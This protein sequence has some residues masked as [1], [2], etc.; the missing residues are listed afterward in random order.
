MQAL[1]TMFRHPTMFRGI[2]AE[3]AHDQALSFAQ[4]ATL[5]N[6]LI[7]L[8]SGQKDWNLNANYRMYRKFQD[9]GIK[10]TLVITQGEHSIGTSQDLYR[11]VKWLKQNY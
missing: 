1:F 4:W 3:C 10:D 11:S 2:I 8:V 7:Y 6:H 5:H 9:H